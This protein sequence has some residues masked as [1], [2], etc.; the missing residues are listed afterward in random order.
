M[1]AGGVTTTSNATETVTALNVTFAAEITGSAHATL[2][3]R[4]LIARRRGQLTAVARM[5]AVLV[6]TMQGRDPVPA[7][8]VFAGPGHPLDRP[9]AA[10][11][12]TAR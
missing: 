10:T 9:P 5:H 3:T 8:R 6:L 7:S 12:E 1:A 4:A 2:T 11:A